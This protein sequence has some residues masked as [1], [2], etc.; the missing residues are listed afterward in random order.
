MKRPAFKKFNNEIKYWNLDRGIKELVIGLNYHRI[1]TTNS[2]EGHEKKGFNHPYIDILA[3]DGVNLLKLVR[4]FNIQVYRRKTKNDTV[5]IILPRGEL[6]LMPELSGRDIG[7]KKKR[8]SLKK[9]QISALE[10]GKMIQKIN[11][12]PES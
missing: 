3:K 9:M 2:C 1:R 6:R 4:W 8:I 11:K 7:S 5:W 12:I 10:F